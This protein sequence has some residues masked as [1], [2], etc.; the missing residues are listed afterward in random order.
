[1]NYIAAL[2]AQ[3]ERMAV[4]FVAT[5]PAMAI[6]LVILLAT[7]IVARLAP[8]IADLMSDRTEIRHS[9]KAVLDTL[10]RVGI[11]LA[12][13]MLAAVVV[14]P[15]L[16]PASLLGAIGVVAVAVGL[17]FHGIFENFLAG[18][19]LM[20]RKKMQI[21]DVVECIGI[22]GRV[23]TMTLRETHIRSLHNGL[24]IMPNAVL[25]KNPV[26]IITDD[27]MRRHEIGM[28]V[29]YGTDLDRAADVIRRAV[30][31][32][33]LIDQ[34]RGVEVLAEGLSGEAVDLL[35][36]WWAGSSPNSAT[37]SRDQ[38]VRAIKR[39]LDDAGIAPMT[40]QAAQGGRNHP[41]R[42]GRQDRSEPG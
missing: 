34:A 13:I 28:S 1:M 18:V 24:T 36:R 11:W 16:T 41:I 17:A 19:L 42:F 25:F 20:V 26:Q 5:L 30:I 6:A 39:A 33:P 10:M 15:G 9:L 27:E 22:C 37:D 35:V 38:V 29:G 12:G 4:G 14:M 3:L 21:G 31:K 2:Q 32:V 40:A 7:W 23:E 8:R